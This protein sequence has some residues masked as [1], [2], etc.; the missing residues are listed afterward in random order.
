MTKHHPFTFLLVINRLAF[1]IRTP[2]VDLLCH[3]AI[4]DM[5]EKRKVTEDFTFRT[6]QIETQNNRVRAAFKLEQVN[7]TF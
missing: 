5:K 3:I 4:Y 6:G 7:K 1:D 2:G